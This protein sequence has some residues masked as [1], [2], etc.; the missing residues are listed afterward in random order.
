MSRSQGKFNSLQSSLEIL[1]ASR[2]RKA[3]F[4][5]KRCILAQ[6]HFE[7]FSYKE[8]TKLEIP[9]PTPVREVMTTSLATTFKERVIWPISLSHD[10][11]IK[12]HSF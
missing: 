1:T 11:I 3:V 2:V 7:R 6:D 9:N 12:N 10:P 5:K 8:S 4:N